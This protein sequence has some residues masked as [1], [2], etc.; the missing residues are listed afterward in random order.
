MFLVPKKNNGFGPFSYKFFVCIRVG[1][2]NKNEKEKE[3]KK[4]KKRN[5]YGY[6]G[7]CMYGHTYSKSID[8]PG[9]IANS[10]SGQLNREN[11]YFPARVS[12]YRRTIERRA[13]ASTKA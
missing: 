2:I 1:L 10:A 4:K 6:R 7:A 11:E 9:K 3:K 13:A 12:A 8:Q 5:T